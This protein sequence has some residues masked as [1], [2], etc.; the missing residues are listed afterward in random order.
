MLLSVCATAA[1]PIV[2]YTHCKWSGP[3]DWY[4]WPPSSTSNNCQWLDFFNVLAMRLYPD[5]PQYT[6]WHAIEMTKWLRYSKI[7]L[8][9]LPSNFQWMPWRGLCH[10]L[11]CSLCVPLML[12]R[13]YSTYTANGRVHRIDPSGL[14]LQPRTIV[15]GFNVLSI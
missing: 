3:Q 4:L 6:D 13:V 7:T 5:I 9:E 12:G 15:N 10:S 1:W 14:L 2:L 8:T 11:C